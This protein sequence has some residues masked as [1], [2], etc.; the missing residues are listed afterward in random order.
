MSQVFPRTR[1]GCLTCRLRKKKC[2]EEKPHCRACKRNKLDCSWPPHIRRRFNLDNDQAVPNGGNTNVLVAV[3]KSSLETSAE[4]A[5]I[6]LTSGASH[7]FT[8][9]A[10]L[11]E[12]VWSSG[13]NTFLSPLRAGMLLPVSQTLLSHYLESTAPKLAPSPDVP[14]VSWV[15]PIAYND[16]LLMHSILALSGA[17]LSY[18][19]Q[20]NI[21][22]QQA[23]CRHY[24]LAV[25]TL[26][27][28]SEDE[29][30]LRK[31]LVLLRVILT[32]MILCHYEV[33]HQNFILA[34][35]TSLTWSGGLAGYLRKSRRI[36]FHPPSG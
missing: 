32:V 29:N 24:S 36:S 22:I 3:G 2:D 1:T 6:S 16:D 7:K 4:S 10:E 15:V 19:S 18:R 13:L 17:H 26:R 31:P 27:R 20:E 34:K 9:S 28:I 12:V 14:F 8:S 11:D 5:S 33:F 25:R 21:T 30:L 23:T 35:M